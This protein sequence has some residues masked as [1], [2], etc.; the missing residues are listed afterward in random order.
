[1]R[2]IAAFASW[3]LRRSPPPQSPQPT[4]LASSNPFNLRQSCRGVVEGR[5]MEDHPSDDDQWRPLTAHPF[6]GPMTPPS[7]PLTGP[8]GQSAGGGFDWGE[9]PR[10]R[11]PRRAQARAPSTSTTSIG[12]A[13]NLRQSG[14]QRIWASVG[15]S[16][17]PAPPLLCSASLNL[18]RGSSFTQPVVRFD[19]SYRSCRE[20][21]CSFGAGGCAGAVRSSFGRSAPA[22]HPNIFL[23]PGRISQA[24]N[25][26]LHLRLRCLLCMQ[27]TSSNRA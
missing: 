10:T 11:N 8:R 13:T 22:N 23:S 14:M 27:H 4:H 16:Q 17:R 2:R 12:N 5:T 26:T 9:R 15:W 25:S 20:R 3:Q 1:M 19:A 6:L 7:R 24:E 21:V 18:G